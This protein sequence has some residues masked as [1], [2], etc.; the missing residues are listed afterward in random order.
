MLATRT[1]HPAQGWSNRNTSQYSTCRNGTL[2]SPGPARRHSQR[3]GTQIPRRCAPG[4]MPGHGALPPAGT[5]RQKGMV[6]MSRITVSSVVR[7]GA[8]IFSLAVALCLTV[9]CHAQDFKQ[10][11]KST[12]VVADS[13]LSYP[14]GADWTAP[15]VL[16]S[17]SFDN[18]PAFM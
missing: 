3:A 5:G 2:G 15:N 4:A 9:P 11:D 17:S 10:I 14:A 7:L 8:G 1:A 16:D 18:F 13:F 12:I 6:P